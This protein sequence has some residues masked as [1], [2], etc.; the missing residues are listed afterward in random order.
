[1]NTTQQQ[2]QPRLEL[3]PEHYEAVS[4]KHYDNGLKASVVYSKNGAVMGATRM[5]CDAAE[6]MIIG[7]KALPHVWKVEADSGNHL[8]YMTHLVNMVTGVKVGV[9]R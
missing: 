7:M 1:M 4:A 3:A 5:D 8:G 9:Y 6:A 2:P